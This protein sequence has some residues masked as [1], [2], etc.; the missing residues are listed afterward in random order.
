MEFRHSKA[1]AAENA[2][3]LSYLTQNLSDPSAGHKQFNRLLDKLGNSIESYPDWHPILTLPL[4]ENERYESLMS[5]SAY[6]GIDHTRRFVKGF[7]TCPYGDDEAQR[8]I[9][10]VKTIKG[11]R[12][13]K[14]EEPLYS[15]S[16]YPVVVKA[17]DVELETDGTIRSRDA[18][19]WCVQDLVKNA[20]N[21]EVAETWWNIRSCLLGEPHGSRSSLLVN[22]YTGG[23]IRKIL[24]SLNSSGIFGPVKERSLEMLSANKRKT[25]SETLIRGAL[26]V[27]DKNNTEE[28]EFELRGEKCKAQIRDTWDDTEELSIKV[29]IRDF[30][31]YATGFY[32]PKKTLLEVRDPTGKQALAKK[33]L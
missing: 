30:D 14:L 21:H 26:N 13:Y 5:I 8:L 18:L 33:F 23:H 7:V 29:T 31:L 20:R 3:A 10:N 27:Y 24:D 19:A 12:A 28:F 11:L 1:A 25:I 2:K 22:Q 32:Y 9:D 15:D 6:S 4:K 16:A 17:I